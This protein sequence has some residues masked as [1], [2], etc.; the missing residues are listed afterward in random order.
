MIFYSI[1]MYNSS[2][3]IA[4]FSVYDFIILFLE[5]LIN[6]LPLSIFHTEINYSYLFFLNCVLA[7]QCCTGELAVKRSPLVTSC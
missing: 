6:V 5:I 1:Y 7:W 3:F 4:C 2:P